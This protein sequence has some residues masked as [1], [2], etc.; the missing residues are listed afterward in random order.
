[1]Q[2]QRRIATV[3]RHWALALI[4]LI[5]QTGAMLHLYSHLQ[6]GSLDAAAGTEQC[7]YCKAAAPLLGAANGAVP[8]IMLVSVALLL[9]LTVALKA[10]PLPAFAHPAYRSRAPP[11]L[12]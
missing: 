10:G 12:I 9:L 5:S 2:A 1:V 6:S 3:W 8:A 4:L 11:R 7:L